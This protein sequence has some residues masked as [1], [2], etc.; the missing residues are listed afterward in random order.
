MEL[1][2]GGAYQGKRE[3][4]LREYRLTAN[5]LC[6]CD[7]SVEPD[8]QARCLDHL[9][10]WALGCLRRGADPA[11]LLLAKARPDVILI[12]EDI[13]AGLPPTD[14]EGRRWRETVGR[15]LTVLAA[16]ADS[17]TRLFCGL[18]QKLKG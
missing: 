15:M 11:A 18:P 12:C 16:R 9:E 6:A 7:A 4:A 2:I 1:L 10:L 8:W 5:E 17:V 14:E 3:Y 13:S